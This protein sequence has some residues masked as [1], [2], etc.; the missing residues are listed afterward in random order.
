MITGAAIYEALQDAGI[1][2]IK[3]IPWELDQGELGICI[4]WLGG[5]ETAMPVEMLGN[6]KD[7][8]KKEPAR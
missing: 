2:E 5:V 8:L 4:T 1:K 6:I 3:I 7:R